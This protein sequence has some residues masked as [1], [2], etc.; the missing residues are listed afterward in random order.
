MHQ[1]LI[2][3]LTGGLWQGLGSKPGST[4][5]LLQSST[6]SCEAAVI[7][8]TLL[9]YF[10]AD[11]PNA[12]AAVIAPQLYDNIYD[13]AVRAGL[14]TDLVIALDAT[15]LASGDFTNLGTAGGTF[16]DAGSPTYANAFAAPVAGNAVGFG[17]VASDAFVAS[18]TT[19]GDAGTSQ[20][21]VFCIFSA[22]SEDIAGSIVSK[23]DTASGAGWLLRTNAADTISFVIEDSIG[24]AVTAAPT[25]DICTGAAVYAAGRY[26]PGLSGTVAAWH[27]ASAGETSAAAVS[28]LTAASAEATTLGKSAS[29]SSFGQTTG[30]IRAVLV[31]VGAGAE[32]VTRTN[33]DALW[34][35]F[36][37]I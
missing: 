27:S 1:G 37:T 5:V 36:K 23:R 16:A 9:E 7:A 25:G 14:G 10:A 20:V 24:T 34:A 8:P 18:N 15:L 11:T 31:W 21:A 13:M 12:T 22:D 29:N 19:M 30:K 33:T 2:V 6:V 17:T 35:L 3:G 26:I 28:L 32:S 4:L